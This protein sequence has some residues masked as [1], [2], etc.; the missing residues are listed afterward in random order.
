MDFTFDELTKIVDR[1]HEFYSRTMNDDYNDDCEIS[2]SP[3]VD[4]ND[5][6]IGYAVHNR[7][8]TKDNRRNMLIIVWTFTELKALLENE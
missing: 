5:T 6:P 8:Y 3:A 4:I 7:Y 2:L 1:L